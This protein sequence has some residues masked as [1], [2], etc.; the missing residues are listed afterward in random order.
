MDHADFVRLARHSE[1]ACAENSRAYRRG[2]M[3]FAALGYLW[4]V[5]CVVLALVLLVYG[6][7]RISSGRIGVV[8]ISLV[9]PALG[10]LWV[11]LKALWQHTDDPD[12]VRLT[13]DDAPELFKSLERIQRRI[14]GPPI[15]EVYL[16]DEFNAGVRQAPRWGLF[17][18]AVNQLTIGLPLLMALDKKRVLAVLA[19]EY[20]HLRGDHGRFG[21]WIYRTRLSWSRL[22]DSM[23]DSASPF[24]VATQ[25]FLRWYAPRFVARTFAMA[26]QDEYEADRVAAKLLGNDEMGAA[27][28]ESE[29]KSAWFD[30]RFWGQHWAQAAREPLPVGPFRAM[31]GALVMQPEGE[32]AQAA[33]RRALQVV[34]S[35]DD[36]HPAM[37]E[38]IDALGFERAELPKKWSRQGALALLGTSVPRWLDHFDRDWCK[39]NADEWKLHHARL[40]RANGRLAAL[41]GDRQARATRT[42][43]QLVEIAQL[44]RVLNPNAKVTALYQQALERDAHHALA[45]IG[46]VQELGDTAPQRTLEYL[47]RLWNA[48]PT[49]RLWA[50]RMAVD[51]L[52]TPRDGRA[53]DEDALKRWRERRRID[54]NAEADVMQELARSPV[55][56]AVCPH[57]LSAMELSELQAELDTVRP[58]TKAWVMR[59]QLQTMPDRRVHVVMVALARS[60]EAARR[61]LCAE[62]QQRLD[63][64]GMVTVMPMEHAGSKEEIAHY[65][66]APVYE[67][68]TG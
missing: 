10:L 55:F 29:V 61:Q 31:Q 64:E 21:A 54:E 2:V 7:G 23:E 8:W 68:A 48:H 12:G 56:E 57:A 16:N 15:H 52:E 14:K 13:K 46:M 17:G 4:V 43:E 53:F 6:V 36:T 3:W 35:V 59:K 9:I 58:V 51:E 60:E 42:P 26:R 22:Y 41:L 18:G 30:G 24:A 25:A 63:L 32:F 44:T 47:E 1:Q 62:L 38:R 34:S 37:R 67:R 45:L 27:L 20:G 66:G 65:A 49:Y 50:A 5:A 40:Q 39:H 28:I 33:L 19:H 11:S